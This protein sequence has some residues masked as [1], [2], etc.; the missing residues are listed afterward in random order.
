MMQNRQKQRP[1]DVQAQP[2]RYLT[3]LLSIGYICSGSFLTG[4]ATGN[5]FLFFFFLS[6]SM[7]AGL[8][9]V[10]IYLPWS[11][12]WNTMQYSLLLSL[13]LSVHSSVLF[14]VLVPY[15]TSCI[16]PWWMI[17]VHLVLLRGG[18]QRKKYLDSYFPSGTS[19]YCHWLF[20]NLR[21]MVA[22]SF[23]LCQRWILSAKNRAKWEAS[24]VQKRKYERN[25]PSEFKCYKMESILGKIYTI[26][27]LAIKKSWYFLSKLKHKVSVALR[28][29]SILD[30][31]Y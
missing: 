16:E 9:T 19:I 2:E 25:Q 5:F 18:P 26:G 4:R 20:L 11:Y 14:E 7:A 10:K 23:I 8:Q 29:N 28:I 13:G 24:N 22:K 12:K 30:N 27:H 3:A 31:I 6:S 17:N 15:S 21:K 1:W